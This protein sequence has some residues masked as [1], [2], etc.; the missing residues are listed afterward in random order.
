[1]DSS[2]SRA[3]ALELAPQPILAFDAE[4]K[5][6][7]MNAAARLLFGLS[8]DSRIEALSALEPGAE[9][10]FDFL[11]S[12]PDN[13]ISRRYVA[14]SSISPPG[15]ELG[16][17][18]G[19]YDITRFG[20][21][22]RAL[23]EVTSRLSMEQEH[24]VRIER[25]M[26][27]DA[28]RDPLTG[29]ANRSLLLNRVEQAIARLRRDGGA[30]FCLLFVDFDGFE[31]IN[32][33]RGREAGDAFLRESASRLRKS[34]RDVDL[35]A[36]LGGDEFVVLLECQGQAMEVEDIAERLAEEISAPMNLGGGTVVPSASIGLVKGSA[37]YASASDAVR[38]ADIAMRL[39]KAKGR[40]CR[41]TF[42]DS[43]RRD[44]S[45]R[46]QMKDEL[47]AAIA[48]GGI[49]LAFQPIVSMD[50]AVTGWEVLA[51]WR[52]SLGPIGPDRFIPLA[53]ET[54]LIVPLGTFVFL[55]T[56]RIAASLIEQGLIGGDG[57]PMP[58]FAINVSTVQLFQPDFAD[59]I[60]SSIERSGIHQSMIHLEIT[61]SSIM[62]NREASYAAMQKLA[63]GGVRF[64]LDDFGTGYSSLSYLHRLPI[65]TIKI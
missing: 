15:G 63:S 43:M 47:R 28:L 1:M 10:E 8:P 35:V 38:D 6:A 36:R 7:F 46:N 33:S 62:E 54:G 39:A 61:E 32:D 26:T 42:E 57:R 21:L 48:S 5:L 45:D 11:G 51:R 64:K 41:V 60:L 22:E 19:L 2:A 16:R 23:T 55:E 27:R 52:S 25:Q 30:G 20:Q 44:A 14:R 9:L 29:L 3:E 37:D 50:G 31:A 4:G 56:L 12:A 65:D 53:E 24:R 59:L 40:N 58:F 13:P 18:V 49:A 17:I 34:L